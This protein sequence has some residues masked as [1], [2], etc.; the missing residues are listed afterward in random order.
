MENPDFGSAPVLDVKIAKGTKL[1]NTADVLYFG[2]NG[3]HV[4]M[5]FNGGEVLDTHQL[6]KWYEERLPEPVFCRC[7]ESFIVNCAYIHCTCGDKFV[8][9]GDIYVKISRKYKEYALNIYKR[10]VSH[11]NGE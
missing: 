6:L 1:I 9:K 11:H 2:G 3:K 10:Y 7:H 4:I 8:L 5:Y